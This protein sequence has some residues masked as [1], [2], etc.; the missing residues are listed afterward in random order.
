ML[1]FIEEQQLY[2]VISGSFSSGGNSA[3]AFGPIRE[4]TWYIPWTRLIPGLLCPSAQLGLSYGNNSV[5]LGR[6]HYAVC[7]GDTIA[8]INSTSSANNR[9]IFRHSS[10]PLGTALSEIR[11]GTS[12]MILLGR[13]GSSSTRST[14]AI[15]RRPR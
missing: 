10:T 14:A 4:T 11:D 13:P 8:N 3:Q 7:L 12:K 9:G 6:R 1:P 2:A 5:W 15:S